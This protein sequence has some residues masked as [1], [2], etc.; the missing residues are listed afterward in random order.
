MVCV[1]THS[2]LSLSFSLS[3]SSGRVQIGDMSLAD[4]ATLCL[5]AIL[6]QLAALGAAEEQYKEIVQYTILDAV[7][8]G[9]RSKVEVRTLTHTHSRIQHNYL[10]YIGIVPD[11]FSLLSPLFLF[12]PSL[13]RACSMTTPT[14]WPVWSRRS[15]P[16]KTSETW[17]SSPTITT[18]SLTSSNT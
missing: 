5:S 10:R 7:R 16:G 17:S 1:L 11:P 14:C 8:K 2:P 4:N 3:L 15:P 6:T 18:P 9:L 12:R 13:C